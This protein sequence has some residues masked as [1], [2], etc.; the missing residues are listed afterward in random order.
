LRGDVEHGPPAVIPIPE[1]SARRA[2]H[3]C[4]ARCSSAPSA[5]VSDQR[6]GND[7]AG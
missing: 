6:G 5:S 4:W 3:P 7:E 2:A 1:A